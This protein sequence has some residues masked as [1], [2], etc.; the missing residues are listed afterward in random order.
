MH[1]K[2]SNILHPFEV[3]Y[4]AVISKIIVAAVRLRARHAPPQIRHRGHK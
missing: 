4:M 2:A 3:T 1:K